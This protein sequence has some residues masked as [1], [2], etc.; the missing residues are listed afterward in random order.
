VELGPWDF[1]RAL[2]TRGLW[3]AEGITNYYGHLMQRRSGVW[4]DAQ[5]YQTLAAYIESIE[6]AQGA[7]LMSAESA[8]MSAPFLDRSTHAQKTNLANTSVSYYNKGEVVGIALDLVIRGRTKGRASLDDVML[9]MYDEF[10]V[11]SPKASYYLNGRGFTNEDFERVTSQVAGSD[12][13][14]F[15]KRYVRNVEPPPYDE[16]F[17]YVGLR[18]VRALSPEPYSAGIA[19]HG[20]PTEGLMIRSVRNNSAAE[21]A[22]LQ[23]D[24]VILTLAGKAVTHDT[25]LTILKQFKIG[26]SVPI[27]VRRDGKTIETTIKVDEPDRYTY[28]IE[29]LKDSTPEMRT[30]R[31][32]WLGGR[33]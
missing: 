33:R 7:T 27:A 21:T 1:T 19:V 23:Q 6:T 11:K 29:A 26:D 16:A 15:F 12:M 8:S 3:I 32:A 9:R 17:G 20:D 2:A 14:E 22:G 25:W 13:S 30:L 28:S 5:L 24:D 4:D 18:L 31:G 10:Y